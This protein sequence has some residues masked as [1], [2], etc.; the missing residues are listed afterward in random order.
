VEEGG[1]V[2]RYFSEGF[3]EVWEGSIVVRARGDGRRCG[4]GGKEE[5]KEEENKKV[6]VVY[7]R[8]FMFLYDAVMTGP[9]PLSSMIPLHHLSTR[10]A[11]QG[12]LSG[13]HPITRIHSSS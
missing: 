11:I 7:M 6:D 8:S 5:G 3:W 10:L 4:R 12:A 13:F 1:W 2:V 9:A